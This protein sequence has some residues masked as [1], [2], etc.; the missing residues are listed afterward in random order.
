MNKGYYISNVTD[1]FKQVFGSNLADLVVE[2]LLERC[3][4][5]NTII[6]KGEIRG[7]SSQR[8]HNC[9][10]KVFIEVTF[11]IKIPQNVLDSCVFI[12]CKFLG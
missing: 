10:N 11:K 2:A 1:L 8:L 7:F 9:S 5:D 3:D 12:N 4:W 6:T